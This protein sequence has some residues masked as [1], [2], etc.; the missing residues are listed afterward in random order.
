MAYYYIRVFID[1]QQRRAVAEVDSARDAQQ[2]AMHSELIRDEYWQVVGEI[3]QDVYND[4][5]RL[6]STIRLN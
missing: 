4:I 2:L 1:H 6:S 3:S 5:C